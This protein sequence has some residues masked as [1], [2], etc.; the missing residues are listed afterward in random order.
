VE[1]RT[2]SLSAE[3][4]RCTNATAPAQYPGSRTLRESTEQH[5]RERIEAARQRRDDRCQQSI[6]VIDER[7]QQLARLSFRQTKR[8]LARIVHSNA[9]A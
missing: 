3:S 1:V 7:R 2:F 6:D 5:Q 8:I 4:N 9:P